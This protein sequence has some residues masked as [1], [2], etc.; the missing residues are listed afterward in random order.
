MPK[1]SKTSLSTVV[2]FPT[3]VSYQCMT[4][5]PEGVC[6]YVWVVDV[7]A[8]GRPVSTTRACFRCGHV[9][10]WLAG[11]KDIPPRTR[12]E[13][14]ATDKQR[15]YLVYLAS[16][17]GAVQ[18]LAELGIS[19]PLKQALTVGRASEAIQRILSND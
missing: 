13:P 7:P 12:T 19:D 1:P 16:R 3:T 8:N 14:L 9:S 17:P 2:S 6:G 18:A 15:R 11:N 4:A 10:S 5:T